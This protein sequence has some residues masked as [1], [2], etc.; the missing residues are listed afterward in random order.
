ML[1]I[2]NKSSQVNNKILQYNLKDKL[3]RNN[4]EKDKP[5]INYIPSSNI[6][7]INTNIKEY[8]NLKIEFKDKTLFFLNP[9]NNQLINKLEMKELINHMLNPEEEKNKIEI[10]NYLI[11]EFMYDKESNLIEF[12]LN[13]Y[14]NSPLMKNI[15]ILIKI[16]SY[17]DDLENN[18]F[19][20]NLN[21]FE[22]SFVRINLRRIIYALL[23]RTLELIDIL[24]K[25]KLK[26]RNN[27]EDKNI[28]KILLNY[29]ITTVYRISKY[30][31]NHFEYYNKKL[32]K[33]NKKKEEVEEL[34]EILSLKIEKLNNNINT[35]NKLI[36]K[37]YNKINK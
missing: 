6:I 32:D 3:D 12:N 35:Q 7:K 18:D 30:V 24:G 17:F 9:I 15:E 14:L 31:N 36:N 25:K 22:L 29:T 13:N 2:G 21:S 16:N 26:F 1:P 20:I 5:I 33:I 8:N 34:R 27:I 23:K 11:G 4:Q 19:N 10:I 28:K 37:Y